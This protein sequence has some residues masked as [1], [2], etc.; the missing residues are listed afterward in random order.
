[1]TYLG[2]HT[3]FNQ[4]KKEDYKEM[5]EKINKRLEGWKS[6]LLSQ[7][8]RSML[9]R[10][11]ASTIPTY[12]MS[13]HMLPKSISESLNTSFKNFWWGTTKDQKKKENWDYER[14]KT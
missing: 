12:Q 11:V 10:T 1:M 3:T 6:K 2:I 13:T 4:S 9:I 14:W 7:A 8:G 5:L